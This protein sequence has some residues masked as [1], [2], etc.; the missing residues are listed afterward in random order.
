MVFT[1]FGYT[2]SAEA[3]FGGGNNS[4]GGIIYKLLLGGVYKLWLVVCTQTRRKTWL[5]EINYICGI[6][7]NLW[8]G[9]IYK[10]WLGG[11]YKL[12]LGVCLAR[13]VYTRA[14]ARWYIIYTIFG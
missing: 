6:I 12:W 2:S 13:C 4:T 7:H 14:L 11:V 3:S 5:V 10:L 8:L 1:N 9:G